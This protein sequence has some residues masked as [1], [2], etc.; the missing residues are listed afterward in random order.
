MASHANRCQSAMPRRLLDH[1]LPKQ[2]P[3]SPPR[4]ELNDTRSRVSNSPPKIGFVRK[5]KFMAT[6][7]GQSGLILVG[8]S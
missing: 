5:K 8:I 3:P 4:P 7:D 6:P 2:M 1:A